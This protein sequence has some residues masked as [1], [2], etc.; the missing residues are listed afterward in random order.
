MLFR[1]LS[2]TSRVLNKQKNKKIQPK[3]KGKKRTKYRQ[4]EE[5]TSH[6][7]EV[8]VD[9]RVSCRRLSERQARPPNQ[10]RPQKKTNVS[11][12]M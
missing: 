9:A 10:V 1:D 6:L 5:K 12:S 11:R 2:R 4:K 8:V 3:K 7:V